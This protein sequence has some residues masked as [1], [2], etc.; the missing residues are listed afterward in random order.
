MH[1]YMNLVIYSDLFVQ[2][3]SD[4]NGTYDT[5]FLADYSEIAQRKIEMFVIGELIG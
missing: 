1:E 3:I 4:G 2:V 5:N